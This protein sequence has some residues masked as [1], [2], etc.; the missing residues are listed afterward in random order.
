MK[1]ALAFTQQQQLQFSQR[2]HHAL[3]ILQSPQQAL[4][5]PH[6]TR[7]HPQSS[8]RKRASTPQLP[9]TKRRNSRRA[10]LLHFLF[11][12]PRTARRDIHTRAL[13]RRREKGFSPRTP[14]ESAYE[15]RAQKANLRS[16]P[17]RKATP[18][19]PPRRAPR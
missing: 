12:R 15:T 19:P 5:T 17:T 8:S 7:T 11:L 6:R 10:Q 18:C 3:Q 2:M 14:L 4:E 1:G 16:D 13:P 9:Q